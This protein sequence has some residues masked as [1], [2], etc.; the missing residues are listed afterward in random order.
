MIPDM[1]ILNQNSKNSDNPVSGITVKD[2]IAVALIALFLLIIFRVPL[3]TDQVMLSFDTRLWPPSSSKGGPELWK[4]KS[5]SIHSDLPG[6]II[7]KRL[8]SLNMI[9][10][11]TPPIWSPYTLGGSPLL[12]GLGYPAYYPVNLLINRVLG[13]N[14]LESTALQTV[15]NLFIAALGIYLFLGVLKLSIMARIFGALS[16][17]ASAWFISHAYIPAFLNAAVWI[18]LLFFTGEK[19]VRGRAFSVHAILSALF[20]GFSFLGGFPHVT[21]CGLYGAGVWI[22]ARSLF[23]KD[24]GRSGL[25]SRLAPTAAFI[26]AAVIA[27]G[28]ASIELIPSAEFKKNSLRSEDYTLSFYKESS[29]QVYGLIEQIAPGFF[30]HPVDPDGGGGLTKSYKEFLPYR[31]FLQDNVQNNFQENALYIGII[32]FLLAICAL[33]SAL[34]APTVIFLLIT[35]FTLLIACGTPLMDFCYHF[36]PGLKVGN[37]KRIMVLYT[38]A[39]SVLA[40]IGFHNLFCKDESKPSRAGT[41]IFLIFGAGLTICLSACYRPMFSMI[42]EWWTAKAESMKLVKPPTEEEL[43][44]TIGFLRNLLWIPAA[45]ALYL[46]I[47]RIFAR[48]KLRSN[49]AGVLILAFTVGELLYF[50]NNLITY[51]QGDVQYPQTKATDFLE[52]KRAE[53][54]PFR[55]SS[56]A[57]DLCLIPDYAAIHGIES[58]GGGSALMNRRYAQFCQAVEPGIIDKEDPRIV[59]GLKSPES[60]TSPLIDLVGVRY[61]AITKLADVPQMEKA[62]FTLAFREDSESIAFFENKDAMQRAFAVTSFRRAATPEEAISLIS[63]KEFNPSIEVIIE[64]ELPEGFQTNPDP[65]GKTPDL[66]IVSYGP[67][68]VEI[69]ADMAGA[70]GFLVLTDNFYPGWRAIVDGEETPIYPANSTFRALALGKGVHTIKFEYAPLTR[71][72]GIAGTS[73]SIILLSVFLALL[74]KTRKRS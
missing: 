25:K 21:L 60:L 67:T 1:E 22:I 36:L 74:I 43:T 71:K 41:V 13:I 40:A 32:P 63:S 57:N 28:I 29:I 62:G 23:G 9:E 10:E 27:L 8:V 73:I 39:L 58:L 34:R 59:Y 48:W 64:G 38:F 46:G 31:L 33:F 37:P 19:M 26:I 16:L 56:F 52:A 6:W 44:T 68:S 47:V 20:I 2:I 11:G 55:V 30:G 45:G 17:C 5:D 69:K 50:C 53:G 35:V 72:L 54:G 15:I 14:P 51:Q 42:S 12:A 4:K 18:P 3:F 66:K 65:N 61:L 49:I 24:H 70:Q 7:P